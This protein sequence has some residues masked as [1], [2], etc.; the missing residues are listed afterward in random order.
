MSRLASVIFEGWVGNSHPSFKFGTLHLF[1][2]HEFMTD[3]FS[4]F[5]IRISTKLTSSSAGLAVSE[6]KAT[7]ASSG[8]LAL[9]RTMHRLLSFSSK[10]FKCEQCKKTFV[11]QRNLREHV[12][13]LHDG[14]EKPHACPECGRRFHKVNLGKFS[15]IKSTSESV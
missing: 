9:G 6:S 12:A 5:I 8:F 7:F 3:P 15:C 10:R 13:A 1:V 14:A 4:K 11:S 2:I